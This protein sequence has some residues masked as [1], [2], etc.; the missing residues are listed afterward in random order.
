MNRKGFTLVELLVV[1]GIITLL[2]ILVLPALS[3]MVDTNDSKKY[4][5]YENMV[6][7][8][9]EAQGKTGITNLCDISGLPDVKEECVGYVQVESD[10][11]YHAYLSCADGDYKSKGYNANNSGNKKC[12]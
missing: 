2:T 11:R 12:N 1:L 8:Y 10:K 6:A 3:K 7:E 4:S 9:A 5:S